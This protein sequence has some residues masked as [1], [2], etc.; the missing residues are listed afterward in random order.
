MSKNNPKTNSKSASSAL[1]EYK[2][3][4]I[5]RYDNDGVIKVFT[6]KD[7]NGLSFNPIEFFTTK[8]EKVFGGVY[9]YPDYKT[10][11]TV[12]FSHGL[13]GGYYN[14]MKEIETLCK[15]GY[16]VVAY[17]NLGCF[18]SDG[19]S[20]K[21]V[22]QAIDTLKRVIE[23][24]SKD[25]RFINYD[26]ILF[27]H[28]WGAFAIGNYLN[29]TKN[30]RIKKA[31]L[32]SPFNSIADLSESM[33]GKGDYTEIINYEKGFYPEYAESTVSSGI[34]S[35]KAKTLVIQSTDDVIIKPENGINKIEQTEN[36]TLIKANGKKHNPNYTESAVKLLGEFFKGFN[37]KVNGG[38]ERERLIDYVSDFDFDKMTEQDG[39]VW[40]KIFDF[41]G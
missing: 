13:G 33:L 28:S 29:F 9:Y 17:D 16:R 41:L 11:K 22:T 5:K 14:Y 35:G 32:L 8:G 26:L 30:D 25:D 18:N 3:T 36:V 7:F 37:E 34:K 19:E 27:G 24:L 31:V 39:E 15:N 21:C 1:V 2:N 20:I 10:G 23:I 40:A 38:A 12:V 4:L 6:E